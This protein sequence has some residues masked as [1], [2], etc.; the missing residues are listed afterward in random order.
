MNAAIQTDQQQ[1]EQLR[2]RLRTSPAARRA[3]LND[4]LA[5]AR[6]RL[7]LD[8]IRLEFLTKL[9]ESKVASSA[10]TDADL[11]HQIQA[12]Q[13]SVPELGS[14]NTSPSAAMP[15]APTGNTW[16]FIRRL[17][18][19]QHARNALENLATSTKALEQSIGGDL[20]ATETSVRPIMAE[21]R[22]LTVDPSPGGSLADGQQQFR[23]QWRILQGLGIGLIGVVIALAAI[24]LGGVL[25]RVAVGRYVQDTYRQ[26]LLLVARNVVVM[27]AIAIVVIFHFASELTVLVTAL[28]FAAAGIA[29]ALQNVILALVR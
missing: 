13:E 15:I 6:N 24:L 19:I 7:E 10:G 3:A 28:G 18:D 27:V 2:Q 17:I 29:F 26:R 9:E 12:L 14:T 23:D 21:L 1:I 22:K 5:A 4:E 11:A 16:G 25:W 8:R 20:H